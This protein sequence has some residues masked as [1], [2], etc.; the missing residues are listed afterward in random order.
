[1]KECHGSV[2]LSALKQ[3]KTINEHGVYQIGKIDGGGIP[4]VC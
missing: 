2:E 4:K 1:M 3:A